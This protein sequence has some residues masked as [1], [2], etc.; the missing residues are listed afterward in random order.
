MD[1]CIR[2]TMH[3]MASVFIFFTCI[4]PSDSVPEIICSNV[5]LC[6]A[7]SYHNFYLSLEFRSID[8]LR[9]RENSFRHIAIATGSFLNNGPR[10]HHAKFGIFLSYYRFSLILE[11]F[12]P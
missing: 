4:T 5:Y 8:P 2:C 12:R 6:H 1:V 11:I 7:T 3:Q 10:N 9:N